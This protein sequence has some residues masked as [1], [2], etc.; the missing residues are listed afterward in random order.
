MLV[1]RL[2]RWP[3]IDSTLVQS[4]P[5]AA[6]LFVSTFRQFKLELQNQ[7]PASLT[8]SLYI[9]L[10]TDI[11]QIQFFSEMLNLTNNFFPILKSFNFVLN[12]LKIV[13]VRA[14]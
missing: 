4:N 2:R 14:L 3:N 1:H 7:F 8:K 11:S 9:Y 6:E 13:Y 5:F 12:W 10:K